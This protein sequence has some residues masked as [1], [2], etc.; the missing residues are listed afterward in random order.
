MTS[1]I[2][3]I[4]A[5]KYNREVFMDKSDLIR[6]GGFAA[7]FTGI[8]GIAFIVISMTGN[9][10]EWLYILLDLMLLIALTGIYLFQRKRS[11]TLG[12]LGYTIAIG[13]NI[14]SFLDF[15]LPDILWR[16][17]SAILGIGL[18]LLAI[19][20]L[21]IAKFPKWVSIFLILA[22]IIGIP[23]LFSETLTSIIVSGIS[24]LFFA[25]G[26]IGAGY[27]MWNQNL[28]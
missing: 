17:G 5:L 13:G 1:F 27:N 3:I 23:G 15:L 7:M 26:F 19:G 28:V 8:L 12:I 11:G 9:E 4:P 2:E 6:W 16:L 18:I 14:I 21:K 22:P 24:T 25:V 10:Q 20:L